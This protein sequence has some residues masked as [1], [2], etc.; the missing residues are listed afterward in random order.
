M[1]EWLGKEINLTDNVV[2]K[3]AQG[4]AQWL[5]DIQQKTFEELKI[6][7]GHDSRISSTNPAGCFIRF[8]PTWGY[9]T[10]LRSR[11]H[12]VHVPDNFGSAL[13]RR[14]RNHRQPSSFQPKRPKIFHQK[15]W[16]GTRRYHLHPASC[17][18]PGRLTATRR[19]RPHYPHQLYGSIQPP[20]A[21]FN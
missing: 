1:K 20:S 17:T 4:F 5:A 6:A 11:L 2:G 18:K 13:R 10:R 16:L 19:A 9:R 15:R 12:S 14:G 3:I 7:V 21:R 8:F